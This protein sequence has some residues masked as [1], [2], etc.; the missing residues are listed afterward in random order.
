[1]KAVFGINSDY[2]ANKRLTNGYTLYDWEVRQYGFPSFWLRTLSGE[3]AITDEEIMFLHSREC[4]I[5]VVIRHFNE[6]TVSKSNGSSEANEIISFVSNKTIPQFENKAIF[7]E[8]QPDWSINHNWMI[9]FAQVLFHNGFI[10]GFIGNT[11]S[12]KNFNFDRQYSHYIHA[13]N[14]V[15]HFGT[16]ICATEPKCESIPEIWAPFAP[17][18]I[19]PEEVDMWE[20]HNNY[21]K[22][23]KSALVFIKD[24]SILDCLI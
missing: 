9:S 3:N 11:D 7:V 13:T 17:S 2:S 18:A 24:T 1:M 21:Y 20:C 4:K 23:I 10:T 12:S 5:G 8:V 6:R 19:E 16:I 14:S 22:T 15:N